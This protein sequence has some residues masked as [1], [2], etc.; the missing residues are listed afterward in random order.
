MKTFALMLLTGALIGCGK[1]VEPPTVFEGVP[2]PSSEPHIAPAA[3]P[4]SGMDGHDGTPF[5][6]A[7][8]DALPLR[9]LPDPELGPPAIP[10]KPS[11]LLEEVEALQ[12]VPP[13]KAVQVEV[14]ETQQE[15]EK[16]RATLELIL[17]LEQAGSKGAQDT[18]KSA[19]RLKAMDIK[20]RRTKKKAE[21]VREVAR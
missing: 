6:A 11:S 13:A 19:N 9:N 7:E 21:M 3:A 12:Y 15:T 17:C 16:A 10:V 5:E 20:A 18:C 4:V 1:P 2:E 8:E 14:F